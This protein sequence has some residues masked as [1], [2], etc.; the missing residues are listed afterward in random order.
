MDSGDELAGQL[1]ERHLIDGYGVRVECALALGEL[2]R[3]LFGFATAIEC[4]LGMVRAEYVLS[5]VVDAFGD[6]C[7]VGAHYCWLLERREVEAGAMRRGLP[8][9]EGSGGGGAWSGK[10]NE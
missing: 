6:V 1:V 2:G 9:R 4:E 5:L 3:M 10:T 7:S 8:P